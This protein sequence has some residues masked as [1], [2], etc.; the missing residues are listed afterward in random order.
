MSHL[1]DQI[2]A[3]SSGEPGTT[4]REP[5]EDGTASNPNA[6][7][8]STGTTEGT[9]IIA[10]SGLT[11][12]GHEHG[13]HHHQH[14]EHHGSGLTGA[15]AGAGVGAGVG[16][17]PEAGH[18][19]HGH[20]GK[21]S[22]V[23][24]H[25]GGQY[26]GIANV[27]NTG[28][29]TGSG[30]GNTGSS[31]IGSGLDDRHAPA[32]REG[33]TGTEDYENDRIGALGQGQAG[34]ERT[35]AGGPATSGAPGTDRFDSDASHSNS[36]PGVG[37]TREGAAGDVTER[38]HDKGTGGIGGILGT[39]DKEFTGRDRLGGA[40]GAYGDEA[41]HFKGNTSGPAGNT[42]LTGREGTQENNPVAQAKSRAGEDIHDIHG[43]PNPGVGSTAHPDQKK[44]IVEK[45]KDVLH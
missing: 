31:G 17:G 8:S 1:K 16:S 32:R 27:G 14:G 45:I 41:A 2:Q 38:A 44:G 42:A 33:G 35:G 23:G 24:E 7:F 25:N 20:D 28:S 43:A 6:Q 10:G 19:G 5:F 34:Y 9:G 37:N 36:R 30:H 26:G 13:H 39:T 3:L 22:G 18:H 29:N 4:G 15:G 40:G 12:Q 21:Y 11:G